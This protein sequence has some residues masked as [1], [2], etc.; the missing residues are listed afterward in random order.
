MS[1]HGILYFISIA[2]TLFLVTG[3]SEKFNIA[4]PYKNYTVIYGLLDMVD[5]AHYIRIQK[6]FSD[7]SKS[8]LVMAQNPDSNFNI[9][10]NVRIERFDY[11]G[12]G[13]VH[14]TIHLNRVDLNLEGYPKQPGIFFDAP[15]YAYKFIN[16]LD[17]YYLYR[18][19]VTN[20]LTGETDSADA[21]IISN[22][23]DSIFSVELLD[24]VFA[25]PSF[26]A[27]NS[28]EPTIIEGDYSNPVPGFT[29][30]GHATPAGIGQVVIRF[31]WTDSNNLT[32]AKTPHYADFFLP[33]VAPASDFEYKLTHMALY[34]EIY[35][36]MGRAPANIYRLIDRCD[37]T[38]Y[39]STFDYS[40]Y[41]E[42]SALLGVGLT[43]STIEPL[44]N[45]I[46]GKAAVGIF[47]SWAV[48]TGKVSISPETIDSLISNQ[49]NQGVRIVGTV[50]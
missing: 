20:P 35:G 23:I 45:N 5:T 21:P 42:Q 43:G 31:N 46:K 41:I 11:S 29:F 37:L 16:K 22:G 14:D 50:Y 24:N 48:R 49:Y 27:I 44:P 39:F 40:N 10:I 18:L 12:S 26:T 17:P 30:E 13:V 38:A 15:N 32:N 33:Y 34:S 1:K 9:G 3:C 6:A 2:A 47:T 8:A 28:Q 4:A 19:V 36:S 7:Q 25:D